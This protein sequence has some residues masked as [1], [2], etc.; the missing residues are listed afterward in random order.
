MSINKSNEKRKYKPPIHC[1]VDL[2]KIKLLSICLILSKIVNPVDVKP[3][4]AS[5]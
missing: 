3:E 4:I 2:H 1:D 5:K